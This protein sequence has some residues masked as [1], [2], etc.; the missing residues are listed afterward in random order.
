MPGVP[1]TRYTYLGPAGT[2]ADAALRTLPAAVRAQVQPS[3]SVGAAL[4]AVR[5]G[6][7]DAALVPLENSVEGAVSTT[8]DELAYGEPLQIVR[9]VLLPVRFALLGRPGTVLDDVREVATHPHAAAQCRRWIDKNLPR[10]QVL[11][12]PSTA[13]AA[14]AVAG[15]RYDAAVSARL[16]AQRYRLDVLADDVQDRDGAVTRF[17]LVAR[18]GPHHRGALRTRGPPGC[19]AGD[20]HRVRRARGEPHPA[21][22]PAHGRRAR[23]LLLLRRLRRARRGRPRRRGVV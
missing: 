9:E 3:T 17:V 16:A 15:G 19:A 13:H 12:A 2:F 21:G 18:R 23:P 14:E 5:G 11:L 22:V 8:L 1:P 4:D 20:A 7:A 6:D 10:A